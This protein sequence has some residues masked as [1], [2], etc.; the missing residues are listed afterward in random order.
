MRV[1][2][3]LVVAVHAALLLLAGYAV[4][5]SAAQK[6]LVWGVNGH[7]LASYPGVSLET[8]LE[9]IRELGLTSYRV[10]IGS[11]EKL[12]DLQHLVREAKARGITVLPVITPGFDMD[13]Q[14]TEELEK[15]A[16]GLAFALV[17]SLKGE[18]PVWELGNELE[19]YAIIQPCEMQDDGKQYSCAYGPAGGVSENEYY[20]PRWAK[21]SAVLKG[22]TRGAHAADP[23][24]KR[25]VGTAGWGHLG[26]FARMKA[27]GIEWDISVWHTYGQNPEW[28]FKELVKYQ[29]PIWVTE[30][31]HP[32]G[33]QDGKEAQ[34]QGLTRAMA[35][36]ADL[37]GTYPIEAA[38]V[39]EL[40]DEPY[41]EG[42]EAHMGLVEMKQDEQG[43][44]GPGQRKPAYEAVK[45]FAT[46]E[47]TAQA[48]P[49]GHVDISRKCELG[50]LP[51]TRKDVLRAAIDYAYCLVVDREAD[52]AGADSW[53][54][55]LKGGM[56]VEQLVVEMMHSDEFARLHDVEKLSPPEYV[57]LIH[58][59]LLSQEP[60]EP[61][62]KRAVASIEAGET[63]AQLQREI[64]RSAEFKARHGVLFARP[65]ASAQAAAKPLL[66]SAKAQVRRTCDLT[67]LRRPLEFERG[68]VIYSYCLV[69]GRWPDGNGLETWRARLR[70]GLTL[71]DF[72][73]GLLVSSEYSEK[74]QA[75]ALEDV[76]FATLSHRLLLGRDPN[77][78]ELD[79]SVQQLAS[80]ELSRIALYRRLL[81]SNEFRT[82][83]EPLFSSLRPERVRVELQRA[84]Q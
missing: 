66:A 27:D 5:A 10:D 36:L 32:G 13:K 18:V 40:M 33:S 4:P 24:V 84:Q 79:T 29:R 43:R 67:V 78:V 12:L 65:S 3:C 62:V 51:G 34:A 35:Q 80:G 56:P 46:R 54:E 31:N 69:L 37:Q 44:W 76:D 71:D 19:N 64:I 55:R 47:A 6:E 7:P 81:A 8:Q 48:G 22:L 53:R 39:Y 30:F 11:T 83:R 26:A 14:S 57:R 58:R 38:H 73:L 60:A 68:Q 23:D 41:W 63:R 28:A 42:Y 59:V 1:I 75:A 49:G 21:V 61:E 20:G 16:Y 77:A 52:N 2:R 50:K 72:L 15:K 82:A 17:S 45:A 70:G 25:A 9:H 74:Y